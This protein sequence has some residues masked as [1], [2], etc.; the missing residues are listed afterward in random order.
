MNIYQRIC[1]HPRFS[2]VNSFMWWNIQCS[3]TYGIFD[4]DITLFKQVIF[5]I[6]LHSNSDCYITLFNLV[7]YLKKAKESE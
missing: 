2:R 6:D 5:A 3:F 1:K 4:L 7:Y